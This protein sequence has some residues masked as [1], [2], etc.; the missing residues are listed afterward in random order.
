MIALILSILCSSSISL[1]LKL[2]DT[3]KGDSLLLFTGNYLTAALISLYFFSDSS[4]EPDSKVILFG[5][6]TGGLFVYAFF[7]FAKAVSAAGTALATVSSRISL[8]IPV[9]LSIVFFGEQPGT[10]AE[11]GLL[12]TIVTIA[13]FYFSLKGSKQKSL[14]V[15]DIFYLVIL[16]LGIG[17]AD[18]LLKLFST[19]NIPEQKPLFLFSVFGFALVYSAVAVL[20]RKTKF[21][22]RTFAL[23]N[24]LGIPNVFTSYFLLQALDE[25]SAFLV[26][27][28][29]NIG[30][31][32]T[33]ASLAA[34]FWK[35]KLNRFGL[36]AL[37]S[38]II[39]IVLLTV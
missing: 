22:V 15:S 36:A 2:N 33:T 37:V 27:P 29:L 35:E 9:V 16:L 11:A 30:I 19:W 3:K 31:I 28:I 6:L 8:F 14:D 23:G 5:A 13:L 21:N 38:G 34:L 25:I 26:Y 10:A 39:T 7:A 1:I 18:F 4:A 32:I 20:V 24:L 17:M 12:F